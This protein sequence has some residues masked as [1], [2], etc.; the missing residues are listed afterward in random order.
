M[1]KNDITIIDNISKI[2][3]TKTPKYEQNIVTKYLYP[4]HMFRIK[5]KQRMDIIK[6]KN[7]DNAFVVINNN[8]QIKYINIP[9]GNQF[10]IIFNRTYKYINTYNCTIELKYKNR[11]NNSDNNIILLPLYSRFHKNCM[12]YKFNI[13]LI[14]FI[15]ILRIMEYIKFRL[16]KTYNFCEMCCM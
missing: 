13:I 8:K 12:F 11:D 9:K 1:D 3:L 10:E 4:C 2:L 15:I 14:G 6:N 16:I 7:I 5:E